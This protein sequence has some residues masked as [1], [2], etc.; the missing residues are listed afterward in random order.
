MV[1][2]LRVEGGIWEEVCAAAICEPHSTPKGLQESYPAPWKVRDCWCFLLHLRWERQKR[3]RRRQRTSLTG[4]L[5][6]LESVPCPWGGPC[7][8]A[9][10]TARN[11]EESVPGRVWEPRLI[12]ERMICSKDGARGMSLFLWVTCGPQGPPRCN[13]AAGEGWTG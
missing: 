10:L 7:F 3:G 11:I 13:V 4:Q 6:E 8:G 9:W 1:R 12:W 5:A 2:S